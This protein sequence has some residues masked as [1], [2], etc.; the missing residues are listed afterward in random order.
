[1][2]QMIM[3]SPKVLQPITNKKVLKCPQCEKGRLCDVPIFLTS[4]HN[5]SISENI[6]ADLILKCPN[7]GCQIG[8]KIK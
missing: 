7:C 6:N 3:V 5:I 4:Q 2:T 8:I 1:M